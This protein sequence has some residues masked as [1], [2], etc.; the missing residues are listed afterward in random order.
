[1]CR[2]GILAGSLPIQVVLLR[3]PILHRGS[4]GFASREL[5][6]YVLRP[7]DKFAVLLVSINLWPWVDKLPPAPA[8]F[9]ICESLLL[10]LFT[11]ASLLL[12]LHLRL[13]AC[14]NSRLQGFPLILK[15]FL[16]L[17]SGAVEHAEGV[18]QDGL[19]AFVIEG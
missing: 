19:L 5:V 10:L 11:E 9:F 13:F 7:P 2:D 4:L 17:G 15:N 8:L 1:M 16:A 3:S 18:G 14:Q 12:W 6:P